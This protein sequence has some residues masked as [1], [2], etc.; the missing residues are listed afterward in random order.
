MP[1]PGSLGHYV[2]IHKLW[3][4]RWPLDSQSLCTSSLP[5]T[6]PGGITCWTFFHMCIH[7]TIGEWAL[8]RYDQTKHIEVLLKMFMKGNCMLTASVRLDRGLAIP[9]FWPKTY[10]Y[11][12]YALV[13]MWQTF[14]C[15]SKACLRIGDKQPHCSRCKIWETVVGNFETM[16]LP[17][18]MKHTMLL[19]LCG[20]GWGKEHSLLPRNSMIRKV[21]TKVLIY[22]HAHS[23]SKKHVDPVY[24][25]LE[26]IICVCLIVL[27]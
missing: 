11:R 7:H 17:A 14:S 27:S 5:S 3:R 12:D 22:S 10:D 18:F 1:S 6:N 25:D 9:S 23:L 26:N 19:V 2:A 20:L 4:E 21:K 15:D 16:N 8:V 13:W 24:W